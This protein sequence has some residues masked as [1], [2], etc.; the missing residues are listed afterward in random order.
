[1]AARR[2][3]PAAASASGAPRAAACRAAAGGPHGG[4]RFCKGLW[5][6]SR[7]MKAWPEGQFDLA[8][9]A[10]AFCRYLAPLFFPHAPP[11]VRIGRS[12]IAIKVCG[13]ASHVI[14]LKYALCE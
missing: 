3:P 8:G 10:A 13:S 2:V 1:M 11:V 4:M 5:P 14:S 12:S 9:N 6:G 7:G